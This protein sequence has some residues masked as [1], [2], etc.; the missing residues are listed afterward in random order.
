[1][2]KATV[3]T[4]GMLLCLIVP[5]VAGQHGKITGRVTD[6]ENGQ[7]L[8]GVDV[9]IEGT[10]VGAA[11]N[12]DGYYTILNVPP[13]QYTLKFSII[14]YAKTTVNSVRVEIDITTTI[15]AE[16]RATALVAGEVVVTAQ[17]PV[18]TKDISAS[19]FNIQ[20]ATVETMPV[21]T[22]ME[23]LT[24]QAGIEQGSDGIVVRGGGT[25]QTIFVV[26]G[27]V[28]N[29]ERSN[30]PYSAVGLSATKEVQVQTGGFNAEYGNV[31]SGVVNIVTKEGERNHYNGNFNVRYRPPAAK[32]FGISLYDPNSYFNRPYT[33][34]T[35]CWTGTK[36]GAWDQNTQNQYPYFQGWNAVALA[37][38]QDKDPSNDLTPEGAK[39][40]WEWQRRRTGD[41]TKP[42]YNLDL[43][44]G[45]PVPVIGEYLGN[46]RFYA[47]YTGER[48]MFIVPLSRDAYTDGH[49]QVKLTSDITPTMK[50]TIMGLYGEEN[51]V[52][53]YEWTTAPTG[54]LM[55]SQSE[56]ADLLSSTDGMNV[57]YMP[58]RYS[59]S[60]V[61]R[62]TLGA[63]LTHML[64]PTTFYEVA[65]QLMSSRY[66][67][68]Q[69]TTR[70]T[71]K[72][73]QP[74]PGYYVDQSPYG[75]WGYST[76]AIDGV[77]STGGWMNLGR[78]QSVNSTS[79]L[80]FSLTSQ[81]DK[82]N[83][84]KA[85]FQFSYDDLNINTG[86]YSPSMSTWTRSMI[87]HVFPYRLGV[88][89]QDKLEFQGFIANVGLRLDFSNPNGKFYDLST[90]DPLLSQGLG[91]TLST[92][93]PESQAK[94][95]LYLS[96]R[97][98]ISH[99]ITEDSKLYFNYGHFLSEPSSSSRFRLQRESNGLVTYLGNPNMELEKTI[100]YELGFEQNVMNTFLVNVAAYYKDITNQPGWIYFENVN[101][102]VHYYKAS[103]NN[104]AD[105]RGFEVTL[106]KVGG[107]WISG[108][109]NYTYDVGSSGYFDLQSY[110]QDVNKQNSY[111]QLNPYQSKPHPQPYAR[112]NVTFRTP[113]GFGP[114]LFGTKPFEGWSLNLLGTW[115]TGSYATYNPNSV[116]GVVDNVQWDDSY[117]VD[118]RLM[119]SI[120]INN[121][122]FQIY[123]DVQNVFN[124]KHLNYAGFADSYDYNDYLASL[125]FPWETGD[126]QGNDRIGD[127]RPNGV[128]YD[129]LESNP[130][131]D[132]AITA[133]NNARK[134][135]KSYINMPNIES[136]TFLNPRDFSFG[137]RLS[138]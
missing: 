72:V 70:D 133:R 108:F 20:T 53:P 24:L 97:L 33:D 39:R 64:S 80:R 44:F 17:R 60:S 77:M 30:I 32:H 56:I 27:F 130:N 68:F 111:L 63:T 37:T 8:P 116:P 107:S 12:V 54:Y 88:F 117:N 38:L 51:S 78:D 119:K 114:E 131:N 92:A 115:Q 98:G 101:T 5:L 106:T 122:E 109:V 10:M 134:A 66:N 128:A 22:V 74:V 18:V 46:L 93:A 13:G 45:G 91:N 123:M 19:T 59:P 36:N 15:N 42:D 85:G 58:G 28:M 55:K 113:E 136:I 69:M 9:I 110:Y 11:T 34:P 61:Y 96:P 67:T 75:Y 41:I 86:T 84:V 103:S 87:Y 120:H 137:V 125:C 47:S 50:L 52:S 73:F 89:A 105:I 79:S 121:Y 31:R 29:D 126:H 23:V 4:I 132:P 127:Y 100:S 71:S 102:T 138:F 104:Y 90:Y 82:Y 7:P 129:P 99:P 112:A 16:L 6:A 95:E 94:S 14:G 1:M 35:V 26:D 43:G 81:L 21:Q 65:A 2:R 62:Y 3:F 135:K 118:L 49:T 83:Q 40:L 124:F 25:N 48:D 76:G 57:L